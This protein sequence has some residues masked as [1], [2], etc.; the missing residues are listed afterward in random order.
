MS[1]DDLI[2]KMAGTCMQCSH[3]ISLS[4]RKYHTFCH[5]VS[6]LK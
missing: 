5:T 4:K 2:T 3:A 6:A 1:R